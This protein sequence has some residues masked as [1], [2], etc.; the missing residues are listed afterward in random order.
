MSQHDNESESESPNASSQREPG[1][2]SITDNTTPDSEKPIDH[3][4]C[5]FCAFEDPSERVVRAHITRED[6]S[7]HKNRNAFLDTI[8]VQAIGTDGSVVEDVAAPGT[9]RYEGES[10]VALVPEDVD[11]DSKT[12]EILSEA[13]QNPEAS[14]PDIS[15]AV[16]GERGNSYAYR[17]VDEYLSTVAEPEMEKVVHPEDVTLDELPDDVREAFEARSTNQQVAFLTAVFRPE[18]EMR[19]IAEDLGVHETTPKKALERYPKHL[20]ALRTHFTTHASA[21]GVHPESDGHTSESESESEA[22]ASATEV[23]T[24]TPAPEPSTSET[25][26][27]AEP[28]QSDED[29]HFSVPRADLQRFESQIS[30]VKQTAEF[31]N[32]ESMLFVVGLVEEFLTALA[33]TDAGKTESQTETETE[34]ETDQ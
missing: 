23:E 10:K 33:D 22:E 11:P 26:I 6:D 32:D 13:I 16:Y 4:E 25:A 8:K 20:E 18:T 15:E 5:P 2:V 1:T 3:Y 34:T 27:E 24:T 12:G 21:A 14:V 28:A 9:T 7:S 31:K 30:G 29:E 17:M 19:E